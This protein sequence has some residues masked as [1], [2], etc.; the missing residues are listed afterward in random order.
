[1]SEPIIPTWISALVA[2]IVTVGFYLRRQERMRRRRVEGDWVDP[3]PPVTELRQAMVGRSWWQGIGW[4]G[5]IK[6]VA[7]AALFGFVLA[8]IGD[9]ATIAIGVALALMMGGISV[10]QTLSVHAGLM[11]SE[12]G[13]LPRY[14]RSG[15]AQ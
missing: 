2:L 1:M 13:W 3:M 6:L 14:V 7:L 5:F 10:Y 9:P 11:R 8:V 4:Y 12:W 15:G